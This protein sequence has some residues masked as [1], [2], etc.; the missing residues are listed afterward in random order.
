MPDIL[1]GNCLRIEA[2]SFSRASYAF[3]FLNSVRNTMFRS[4]SL[5]PCSAIAQDDT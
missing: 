5:L 2:N 3:G 1:F 4:L